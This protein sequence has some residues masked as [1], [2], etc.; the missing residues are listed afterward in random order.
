MR[1]LLLSL[2][3]SCFALCSC[4][5]QSTFTLQ[6]DAVEVEFG[7][8]YL[9]T[10]Y[11]EE[12]YYR[13]ALSF[14]TIVTWYP[15]SVGPTFE[16]YNSWAKTKYRPVGATQYTWVVAP[17]VGATIFFSNAEIVPYIRPLIGMGYQKVNTNGS[18]DSDS[19]F[20]FGL[21]AGLKFGVS[22]D[23]TFNTELGWRR[24]EWDEDFGEKQDTF[25]LTFG[26]SIWF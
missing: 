18:T 5:T 11:P 10:E 24:F 19:C 9:Y 20:A 26:F 25:G 22:R 16:L 3:V 12:G 13:R 2:V 23:V 4:A 17:F 7:G 15:A 1:N 14:D 6:Q 21:G 8:S